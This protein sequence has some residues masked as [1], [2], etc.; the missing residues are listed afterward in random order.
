MLS[1]RLKT[2]ANLVTTKSVIDVGCDHGYLDIYLTSKGIK[3]IATDISPSSLK[4]AEENFKKLNLSIETMC[5]DGLKNINISKEDTIVISGMGADTIIKILSNIKI[6]NDLIISSNNNLK[7]LRRNI[8][9]KGYYIEKELY[10]KE[11]NISYVIIKFKKGKEYYN[12]F[13]YIIGPK[14]NDNEYFNYMI[15]E[16]NDILNKIP[17]KYEDEKKY[18]EKL[19]EI[20]KDKLSK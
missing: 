6:D 12:D 10:V 1:K 16:Y 19:I 18:Y 20:L 14:I 15:N 13:E 17:K 7:K 4:K 8:C 11:K 3:C 2:I 5:T 9:D